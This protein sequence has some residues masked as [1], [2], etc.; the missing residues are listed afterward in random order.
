MSTGSLT[1]SPANVRVMVPLRPVCA[2]V[3]NVSPAGRIVGAIDRVVHRL[4]CRRHSER[5][6]QGK[7]GARG[8]VRNRDAV[9]FHWMRATRRRFT[10][11]LLR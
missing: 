7:T 11:P 10:K 2:G 1:Y 6:T 4:G 3:W 9:A 5:N 8:D